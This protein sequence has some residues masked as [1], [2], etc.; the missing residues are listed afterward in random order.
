MYPSLRAV[1]VQYVTAIKGS[2]KP[3]KNVE[4]GLLA[5]SWAKPS[6]MGRVGEALMGFRHLFSPLPAGF[7]LIGFPEQP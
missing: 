7:W 4:T 2:W 3:S 1:I 6:Q 5:A